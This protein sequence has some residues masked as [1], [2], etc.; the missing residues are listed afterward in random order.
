[1]C[2]GWGH[3]PQTWC[4]RPG[5]R[6]DLFDQVLQIRQL[7]TCM[8]AE[9]HHYCRHHLPHIS[10]L[11]EAH[12]PAIR[13]HTATLWHPSSAYIRHTWHQRVPRETQAQT[14]SYTW[15]LRKLRLTAALM[16][17]APSQMLLC[18]NLS[19]LLSFEDGRVHQGSPIFSFS[20][21]HQ[22][23]RKQPRVAD[24]REDFCCDIWYKPNSH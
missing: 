8:R 22:L 3:W 13:S 15:A 24:G 5:P 17:T 11:S 1:M 2:W 4:F 7:Q 20:E 12:W 19:S 6:P 16:Q 9:H 23:Q 18:G 21:S 10:P 14:R